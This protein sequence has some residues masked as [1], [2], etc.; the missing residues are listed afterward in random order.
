M[1]NKS[2]QGWISD[3][4]G[5]FFGGIVNKAT[6]KLIEHAKQAFKESMDYLF[7]QKLKPL[8]NQ[9]EAAAERAMDHAVEDINKVVD[10]FEQ[11]MVEMVEKAAKI[12]EDFVDHTVEEI[13]TKIIDNTFD[14][15]NELEEK[16]F[17]DITTILNKVDEILQSI[18]CY[19]HSVIDRIEEDIKKVLPSFYNPFEYCRKS[20]NEIFPGIRWKL[21]NNMTHEELYEYRKCLLTK[22][23]NEKSLVRTI[24][25]AYR[26]IELL[27]GNMRCLSVALGSIQNEKFYI[28]EMGDVYFILS[29]YNTYTS[30]GV[31]QKENAIKFLS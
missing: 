25:A 9:I 28:K 19:A 14:K 20:L 16:I 26:E 12:A 21:V 1:I 2:N 10:N 27:A 11:K 7:D 13:K 15:L 24:Q 8:I 17:T 18:S 3:K 4:I 30:S 22:D 5:G 23:L 31:E 6:D 29:I